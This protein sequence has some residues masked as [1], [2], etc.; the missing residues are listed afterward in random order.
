MS[1][2]EHETLARQPKCTR[3]R[4]HGIL[5]PKKG[6]MKYCPFL[7]CECWKCHLIT[8]RTRITALQRNPK[9]ELNNPE[10]KEPRP[11]V[12]TGVSVVKPAADGTCS[13]SAPDVSARPS[14]TS[15]AMCLPSD[16]A[17]ERA[18]TVWSP[19]DLRT[20]AAARG[21][22]VTGLDIGKGL[23]FA[24][25]E[26]RPP[27]NAPYFGEFGQTA[28]LPVLHFPF[29]MSGHYP[30]SYAP[31]PNLLFNM[32]WLPPVPAGLFNDSLRGPLMFPH[33]QSHAVHYPP[34]PEPGPPADCRPVFFTLQPPPELF[35]EEKMLRQH[36]QPP[37]SKH[38]EQVI[39]LLD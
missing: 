14:A 26:E 18:A 12:H 30:S 8:Q 25:S 21:E 1:S 2:K 31:C 20:R 24:S 32:P 33:F 38:T 3:C 16:G 27:I 15:G 6:H 36:P 13:A 19:L 10:I 5:V 29:T 28:P 39:D 17:P 9:K 11:R 37:V 35:Q 34:P 7:K 23:P 22:N 4:H